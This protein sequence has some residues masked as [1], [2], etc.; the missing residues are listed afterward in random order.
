MSITENTIEVG[1]LKWFYRQANPKNETKQPPILFIH[2]L[3]AHSFI[4]HELMLQLAQ[5]GWSAIAPDWIGSG[6]SSQPNQRDFAYNQQA[7]LDALADFINT[8]NLNRFHL[9]IQGFLAHLG[10]QH[11]LNHPDQIE[12]L[13]ILNT[14]LSS[15][16][17]LPATMSRWGWPLVGDMLTQDPLLVDRSLEGG[18]GFVI[19]D[20]N[21]AK[22]RKPFIQSSDAGRALLATIKQLNL[23]EAMTT[24]ESSLSQWTKPTLIVWGMADPWLNSSDAQKLAQNLE[25]GELVELPEAKHYPQEHWYEEISAAMVPF[26]RR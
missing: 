11:A 7:Y 9:V 17:K 13:I 25:Q 26:L 21:L 15:T 12:S 10:L 19:A 14:P 16:A 8:I 4:W 6:F 3:P 23:A 1:S 5:Q 24:M 20:Q 2:G 22:F 18:S